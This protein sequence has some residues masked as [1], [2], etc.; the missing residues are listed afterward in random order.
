MAENAD[1]QAPR[2]AEAEESDD[3]LEDMLYQDRQDWADVTPV[4]Q[5]DGT[6]PACPIAYTPEFKDAMDY[7]RAVFQSHEMSERAFHLTS[8]VIDNNPANYTVW[9]FR[10]QVIKALSIDLVQELSYISEICKEN[11]KNYQV[12]YHRRIIVEWKD[13]ASNELAFTREVLALDGKNYHAWSHRH[14]AMA[15][16]KLFPSIS[17]SGLE[18]VDQL[19]VADVLNN[20]A[21]NHR[22]FLIA[23]TTGFTEPVVQREISYALGK[24]RLEAS[25]ES[26]WN[27]LQGVCKH[28]PERL[29]ASPEI[30]ARCTAA[31]E[32]ARPSVYPLAVLVDLHVQEHVGGDADALRIA[33]ELCQDLAGQVDTIRAKYWEYRRTTLT[34]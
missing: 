15:A 32:D 27:Y 17:D 9:H 28:S 11:P 24:L 30:K 29:L 21:W 5:S 14:W 25:N 10:R 19:L 1:I 34:A 33:D 31:R 3:E 7:F 4:P 23:Q 20:S 6:N 8:K 22:Y 2:P 13:D 12:W 26:G 16:Y 18:Y